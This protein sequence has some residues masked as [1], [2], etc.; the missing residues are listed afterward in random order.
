MARRRASSPPV[1]KR[2]L[3]RRGQPRDDLLRQLHLGP[4]QPDAGPAAAGR[5]ERGSVVHRGIAVTDDGRAV[6]QEVVNEAPAIRC[7]EVGALAAD[8]ELIEPVM[9]D[10]GSGQHAGGTPAERRAVG[11]LRIV[12]HLLQRRAGRV[13]RARPKRR[14]HRRVCALTER[15]RALASRAR[16]PRARSATRCQLREHVAQVEVDGARAEEELLANLA[17]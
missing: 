13:P 14:V 17:V 5:G 1:T 11:Q 6:G 3:F 4:L 8:H 2:D 16:A 7:P 12:S 15:T 9:A 10:G